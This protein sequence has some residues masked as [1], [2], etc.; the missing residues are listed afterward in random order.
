MK[1]LWF[2][3]Y[4]I[5]IFSALTCSRVDLIFWISHQ[6]IHLPYTQALQWYGFTDYPS[7][8]ERTY[9]T[10][11]HLAK[12]H[13]RY[14]IPR[15]EGGG[16]GVAKC[17]VRRLR[18]AK[19]GSTHCLTCLLSSVNSECQNNILSICYR[20]RHN[21]CWEKNILAGMFSRL[22]ASSADF[23]SH[24]HLGRYI[25]GWYLTLCKV[26]DTIR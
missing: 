15:R 16:G 6:W 21:N 20:Y 2:S 23:D 19:N 13:I 17:R 11:L 9:L 22:L 1:T 8:I 25:R 24:H 18:L 7:R 3:C 10:P 14:F 4:F 12:L 26:A 5:K